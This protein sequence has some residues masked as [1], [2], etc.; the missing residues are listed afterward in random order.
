MPSSA[1]VTL[2]Q[3]KEVSRGGVLS[4]YRSLNLDDKCCVALVTTDGR[5][6]IECQNRDDAALLYSALSILR[7]VLTT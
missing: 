5:I 2:S 7:T 1:A 4:W 3:V 6:D